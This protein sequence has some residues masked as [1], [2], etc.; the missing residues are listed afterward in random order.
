MKTTVILGALL[1]CALIGCSSEQSSI[2]PEEQLAVHFGVR[3]EM[4]MQ[5]DAIEGEFE[6][7]CTYWP[8]ANAVPRQSGGVMICAWDEDGMAMVSDFEGD[9]MGEPMQMS[10]AMTWDDVRS[11]Y[12]GLWSNPSGDTI[13]SLG[14]GHMDNDGAIVTMR[15]EDEV[16]VREV[17]SVQSRD[18]HMREIYRT[19]PAGDEYISLR[20]EMT[21]IDMMESS[22]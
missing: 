20:I 13:M 22:E 17:L 10:T 11:C 14:D 4:H 19:S 16:S 7:E 1:S 15:C 6:A 9:L 2:S 21:R 12:V 5:L 8:R 18:Q 3:G